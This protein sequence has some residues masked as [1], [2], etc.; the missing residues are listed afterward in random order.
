MISDWSRPTCSQWPRNTSS[1]SCHSDGCEGNVM[2][3]WSAKRAAV[4]KVRKRPLPPTTIG[5]RSWTGLGSHRASVS[6]KYSPVKSVV[7]R[8]SSDTIT[9]M[10]SSKRSDRSLRVPSGMP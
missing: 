3:H 9:S 1:S 7:G 5:M 4:R 10:P 6:R 2:S 8:V